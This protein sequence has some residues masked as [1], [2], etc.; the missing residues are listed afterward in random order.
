MQIAFHLGAPHTDED[1][2]IWSLREDRH[3]LGAAGVVIPRPRA[4]RSRMSEITPKLRGESLPS[5]EQAAMLEDFGATADTQRVVL[6][7]P[8]FI[9]SPKKIWHEGRFYG[10]AG[11]KTAWL[12]QTFSDHQAEFFLGVRN[13]V[14]FLSDLL[15]EHAP[16]TLADHTQGASPGGMFWSDVVRSIRDDN[17]TCPVTVWCTEDT[18]VI[19]PLVMAALGGIEP[20]T[21]LDG[22]ARIALPL[23]TPEGQAS[24]IDTIGDPIKTD[25]LETLTAL[26]QHMSAYV[27]EDALDE[28]IDIPGWTEEHVEAM[29]DAYEEDLE[30]IRTMHGITFIRP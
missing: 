26:D 2:L 24:L 4:Y 25:M 30:R 29:T 9:C 7:D 3:A 6:S 28:V 27:D 22:A 19:W 13:P 20:D 14:S 23:L 10:K 8:K 17:P 11:F 5:H 12:R 21:P 16:M 1:Q 15:R 18:P